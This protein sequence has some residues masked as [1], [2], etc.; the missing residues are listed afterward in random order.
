MCFQNWLIFQNDSTKFLQRQGP[1]E[2]IGKT[3]V[4]KY[5]GSTDIRVQMKLHFGL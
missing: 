3:E 1:E 5:K 4:V 2:E